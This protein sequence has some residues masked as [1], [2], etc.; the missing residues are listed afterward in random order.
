MT[1]HF[2]LTLNLIDCLKT[3]V[4]KVLTEWL[5]PFRKR[6][7][8]TGACLSVR[9]RACW[10]LL[11][12]LPGPAAVFAVCASSPCIMDGTW[13]HI[14]LLMSLMSGCLCVWPVFCKAGSGGK[15]TNI[16]FCASLLG[17]E[18]ESV[19]FT[20]SCLLQFREGDEREEGVFNKASKNK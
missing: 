14:F 15:K 11:L 18:L 3:G 2:C 1:K 5:L 6:S 7:M 20:S 19:V 9:V 12:L 8:S 16:F 13:W 17:I 4:W 10:L